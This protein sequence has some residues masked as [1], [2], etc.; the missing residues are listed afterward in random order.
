MRF[1]QFSAAG[2]DSNSWVAFLRQVNACVPP[3]MAHS[4]V[5]L[6]P[7]LPEISVGDHSVTCVTFTVGDWFAKMCALHYDHV[8]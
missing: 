7:L 5:T 2:L 3:E 8:S 6:V 4:S 1:P